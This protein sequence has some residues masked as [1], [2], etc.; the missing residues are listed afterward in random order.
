[1]G[2]HPSTSNGSGDSLVLDES[3]FWLNFNSRHDLTLYYKGKINSV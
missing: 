3:N 2:G 1:M